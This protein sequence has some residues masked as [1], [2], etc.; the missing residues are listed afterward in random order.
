MRT[1]WTKDLNF[2]TFRQLQKESKNRKKE[3]KR[4]EN[5]LHPHYFTN[6]KSEINDDK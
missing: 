4:V 1:T 6:P 3:K 2:K 5:K